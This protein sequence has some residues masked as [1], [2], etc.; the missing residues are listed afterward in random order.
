M[1][2]VDLL[3]SQDHAFVIHVCYHAGIVVSV[4]GMPH[5]V[6]EML[7]VNVRVPDGFYD[8]AGTS[9]IVLGRC[10]PQK[11]FQFIQGNWDTLVR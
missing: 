9:D 2:H 1:G 7:G 6:Y 8:E 10:C 11:G 4:R 3:R 5:L